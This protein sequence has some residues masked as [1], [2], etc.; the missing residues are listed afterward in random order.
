MIRSLTVQGFAL[1]EQATLDFAPG[2][3][4]L[5]GETG[6]GKSLLLSALGFLLGDRFEEHWLR[7]GVPAPNVQ[8]VLELSPDHP[9][10]SVLRD[11][12]VSTAQDGELF[13]RRVFDTASRRTR[14]WINHEAVSAAFLNR[15]G[16]ELVEIHGQH[17][18][19]RIF[20]TAHHRELLDRFGVEKE[21]LGA[22]REAA[23]RVRLLQEELDAFYHGARDAQ[24]RKELLRFQIQEL[25]EAGVETLSEEVLREQYERLRQAGKIRQALDRAAEALEAEGGALD[26]LGEGVLAFQEAGRFDKD[27]ESL[28]ERLKALQEELQDIT[29]R[30]REG[31]KD[32]EEDAGRLEE[33]AERLEQ[34]SKLRKKY[35]KDAS[36]MREYL[37]KAREEYRQLEDAQETIERRKKELQDALEVYRAHAKKLGAARKRAGE[38]L[39]RE[40]VGLL[41][42]LGLEKARFEVRFSKREE[43][44]ENARAVHV[45]GE[46]EVAFWFSANP[47]EPL[48]PLAA[49][50]SGGEASRV[51][52]ALKTV[53][54]RADAVP[55]LVFDE[56]DTG[57]GARTAPKVAKVLARLGLEKQV[58]CVTHLA[59]LA[60]LGDVHYRVQKIQEK[61]K[62]HVLFHRLSEKERLEEIAR[63][64]GGEPLSETSLAHAKELYARIRAGD[65]FTEEPILEKKNGGKK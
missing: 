56:V 12:G 25:E 52:L 3:N 40:V 16:E 58:L 48:R 42:E 26:R 35:G 44:K 22:V 50:A 36:G 54:A 5:T 34:W 10:F 64:L 45:F 30:M 47:G 39:S 17:D 37:Q 49:V 62:T 53:L 18:Q 19:Q 27:A 61:G 4:L 65:F 46:E 41:S 32:L 31:W 8:A 63:M 11:A 9:V 21:T 7:E 23:R 13:I 38:R 15:V 20:Q 55:T 57:I 43:E 28:A 59:P 51:L 2:V 6:A 29:F 24:H 14:T 33:L 1:V 60:A